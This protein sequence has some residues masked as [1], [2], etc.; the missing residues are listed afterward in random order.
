VEPQRLLRL[1]AEMK[2]PGKA[3]LQ[4]QVRPHENEKTLLSQTAIFAPKGLIGLLY[5]YALYPIHS[6]IFSGLIDEIG[7]RAMDAKTVHL[8]RPHEPTPVRNRS[9]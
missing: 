1:R 3:W 9:S 7:R 8:E 4:F 6:L 5:W 2:V